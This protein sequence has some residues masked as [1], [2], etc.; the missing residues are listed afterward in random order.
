MTMVKKRFCG[1]LFGLM[2][3]LGSCS[4]IEQ[5]SIVRIKSAAEPDTPCPASGIIPTARSE[6]SI[7]DKGRY[8]LVVLDYE[9]GATPRTLGQLYG[10]TVLHAVPNYEKTVDTYLAEIAC[11]NGNDVY[12][13]LIQRA[14]HIVTNIPREYRDEMEGFAEAFCGG[15]INKKGD[16]KLSL[17]EVYLL[18]LVPDVAR[19]TQCSAISV[20][21]SRS[22]TGKTISGRVLDWF[23]GSEHQL[24]NLQAVIIVRNFEKSICLIGYAGFLGCISGFNNDQIFAAILDSPTGEP[25]SAEK[26]RSYL[27]DLRYALENETTLH[28]VAGFMTDSSRQYTFNHLILLSDA[29][30]SGILENNFSGKGKQMRRSLRLDHSPLHEGI[31]WNFPNAVCGVNAF[32]LKGNHD[33]FTGAAS[34]TERWKHFQTQLREA[35]ESVSLMEMKQIVSFYPE[36]DPALSKSGGIY[37]A[38]TQQ[39]I[40]YQPTS[41]EL[42]IFFRPRNGQLPVRPIFEKIIVDF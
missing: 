42:E 14:R 21:G 18:N 8:Y 41:N 31:Q 15:T 16:G 24:A 30:K 36:S 11:F 10:R 38:H 22:E 5:T 26:K 32:M 1:F 17:D 34:N 6:V 28:Q 12:D 39:I 3:C 9:H 33:N 27:F 35:G 29:Q 13:E 4:T 40:L 25:F 37:N 7:T 2:I 23:G 20:F 19:A